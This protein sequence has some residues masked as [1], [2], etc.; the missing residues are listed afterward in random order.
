MI[1]D[2]QKSYKIPLNGYKE[3]LF[4]KFNDESVDE[5]TYQQLIDNLMHAAVYT[6][7]D[8]AFAVNKLSQFMINLFLRYL[9]AA[10][11]VLLYLRKKNYIFSIQAGLKKV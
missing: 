3:L 11:D 7:S 1:I 6:Q 10:R 2:T 9:H 8:I 5:K 4:Y